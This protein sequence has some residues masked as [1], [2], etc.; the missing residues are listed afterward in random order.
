MSFKHYVSFPPRMSGRK[1]QMIPEGGIKFMRKT[2]ILGVLLAGVMAATGIPAATSSFNVQISAASK[3]A[4]PTGISGS[5]TDTTVKLSWKAVSGADAYRVY[6]YNSST[7][8]Y[9]TLQNVSKTSCKISGLTPD[10]TYVFKVA[11]LVKSGSKYSA[12]TLSKE[13]KAKTKLSAPANLKAA[14]KTASSIKLTWS[15]VKGASA[16]RVYYAKGANGTLKEYK[17]VSGT[18]CNVK[19]LSASTTY[20]FAVSALVKN[21]NKYTE[22]AVSNTVTASTS[23]GK[24][25]TVTGL[26]DLPAYGMSG[27]KAAEAIGLKDYQIIE[28]EKNGAKIKGYVGYINVNGVPCVAQLLV[29][30]KGEYFAGILMYDQNVTTFSKAYETLKASKGKT[31]MAYEMLGMQ[32]YMWFDL[33]M[34][35]TVLLGADTDGNSMTVYCGIGY[36]YAPDE[37]KKSVTSVDS[38]P[39]LTSFLT[40]MQ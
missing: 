19:G 12:Q 2:T 36:K 16:Y 17:N 7:K 31:V 35:I 6:R 22:Q 1:K 33:K 20:G 8:K 28:Q 11:A 21:G 39:D 30:A 27:E 23:G 10:T 18:S 9:E 24:T 40:S 26:F 5:T 32:M 4:A 3:L 37:L 14:S 15:A 34:N 13:I 25:N 29:N 38:I